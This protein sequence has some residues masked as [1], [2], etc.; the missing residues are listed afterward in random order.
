MI[1]VL[2]LIDGGFLGGGQ[3]HI[4]SIA[5]NIDSNKFNVFIAGSPDGQFKPEVL[6]RGFNFSG[7]YLPKVYRGKHL[8]ALDKIVSENDIHII[9][10]HGGVAGMYAR[11][12]KKR[13]DK[14]KVVHTIH[15]IHYTRTKNV[16]RKWFS[17]T[18]E[19][20]LV[21]FTDKFI[22]VSEEDEIIAEDMTIIDSLK[23]IVIKNGI[24]V[25]KF[26]GKD[27]DPELKK[28]FGIN[29]GDVV[30]GNISRFDFQ[31][32]QRALINSF[33]EIIK[34]NTKV[35]LLLIGDGQFLQTCR[36]QVAK[37]GIQD[38][39]IFTGEQADVE[40]YYPLI[41]V[42]IFPSLWE[43]LSISLIEAMASGRCILLSDIPANR[44]LLKDGK[45]GM[46][47]NLSDN[48]DLAKKINLLLKDKE[49]RNS[50]SKGAA[51]EALKYDEKVMTEK[52]MKV[53]A[54]V[55]S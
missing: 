52:I 9:H 15:G 54:E 33:N 32:N 26:A 21:K 42:F 51:K 12:F 37:L 28:K 18:I 47:F 38:K 1:N 24:D 16:F 48:D 7:I 27:A 17:Q 55:K 6:R 35:K 36:E 3:T 41:D 23:T 25:D 11:F 44:E 39:V 34:T 14:V 13:S 50:L 46:F 45:T 43:G 30:L 2:E 29:E 20:S 5:D 53:Y 8:Q 31:K 19:E 4:L 40:K 22:C 10:S 49:K